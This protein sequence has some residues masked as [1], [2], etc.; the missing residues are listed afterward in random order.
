MVQIPL[1]KVC[2]PRPAALEGNPWAFRGGDPF[3]L[4][5]QD[6]EQVRGASRHIQVGAGHLQV[7]RNRDLILGCPCNKGPVF[8]G[9]CIR[10]PVFLKL[11]S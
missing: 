10:A 6:H 2:G 3:L 4:G 8:W 11:S 7:S 5:E 9:C 1:K